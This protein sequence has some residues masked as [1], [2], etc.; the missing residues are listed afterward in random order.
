MHSKIKTHHEIRFENYKND[1]I[2]LKIQESSMILIHRAVMAVLTF[3]I[4]LIFPRV[5]ESQAS[6]RERR[7]I[8]RLI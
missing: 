8:H 6:N 7:E 3:F 2:L 1:K 5:P 4:K